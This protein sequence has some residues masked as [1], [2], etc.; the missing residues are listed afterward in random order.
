MVSTPYHETWRKITSESEVPFDF[1]FHMKMNMVEHIFPVIA[2]FT[3]K[4]ITSVSVR[5]M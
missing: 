1:D 5:K 3:I 2:S 4:S